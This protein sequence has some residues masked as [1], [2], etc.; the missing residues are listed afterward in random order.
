MVTVLNPEKLGVSPGRMYSNCTTHRVPL[1]TLARNV[2]LSFPAPKL[3]VPNVV[4]RA[5]APGAVPS[6]SSTIVAP[7]SPDGLAAPVRVNPPFG[8]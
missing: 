5:G 1:L 8:S 2:T 4:K 3:A 6:L 7:D